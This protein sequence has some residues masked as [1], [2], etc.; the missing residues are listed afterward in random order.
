MYLSSTFVISLLLASPEGVL[1]GSRLWEAKAPNKRTNP[2]PQYP[3][4]ETLNTTSPFVKRAMSIANRPSDVTAPR[5]WP[6]K[7]MRYC[8]ERTGLSNQQ[9][10]IL[11]GLFEMA[12]EKWAMLGDHGFSYEEVN[13][14]ICTRDRTTVLRVTYSAQGRLMSSLGIPRVDQ[15]ANEANPE[16]AFPGPIMFLSDMAGIG[17]NDINANVGHELG[18]AWGLAHEHQITKYW[19]KS[20][21]DF[22]ARWP[23]FVQGGE[24]HFA[25]EGFHCDKL[26]DYQA[27]HDRVL[28]KIAA[29]REKD[30]TASRKLAGELQ[31]DLDRLCF[32]QLA[33]AKHGFS[34]GEWLPYSHTINNVVDDRFDPDSLMMYPSRSGGTG[35]GDSRQI[36]MTY[37]DGSEIPPRLTPSD[38]D[39]DRLVTLYGTSQSSTPGVVHTSKASKWLSK[40]KRSR[41]QSSRAGD[42][43]A[44]LC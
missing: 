1:G 27:A 18:H 34:A 16:Q 8:F 13:N 10:T 19:Q 23:S 11:R 43:Q 20:P 7:K 3:A 40:F 36:V 14:D 12:K 44:G 24:K 33:A 39:V 6:N 28:A 38:M 35:N 9:L 5:L 29:A 42:T 25:T 31:T 26:S 15:A 30:D 4:I 32:S 21:G 2:S 37:A 41:G 17:Q 22:D